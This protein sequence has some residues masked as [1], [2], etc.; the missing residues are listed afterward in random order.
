MLCLHVCTLQAPPL[1]AGFEARYDG[2]D[3]Y[4]DDS[5][6]ESPN[7][8]R[9]DT[10]DAGAPG[11]EQPPPQPDREMPAAVIKILVTNNVAGGA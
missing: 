6:A 11:G 3:G 4:L 1:G 5:G 7:L 2:T 10:A 8:H 9:N